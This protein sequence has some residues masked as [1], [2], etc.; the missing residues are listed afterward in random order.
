MIDSSLYLVGIRK[1]TKNYEEGAC[2]CQICR[3]MIINAG[4]KEVIVRENSKN[5][6]KI[7]DVNTWIEND[8]LLD[9][10]TTY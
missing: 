5:E 3:K 9:G 10:K 2:S 6:Y 1:D 7:I 8:D 4:I